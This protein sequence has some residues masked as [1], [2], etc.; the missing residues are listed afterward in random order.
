MFLRNSATKSLVGVTGENAYFG[1]YEAVNVGLYETPSQALPFLTAR[2]FTG[3]ISGAWHQE[4]AIGTL[5]LWPKRLS[6]KERQDLEDAEIHT[7][8]QQQLWPGVSV[9][10]DQ[11]GY[12]SL[13]TI[14]IMATSCHMKKVRSGKVP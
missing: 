2:C 12:Q 5:N 8:I 10:R 13:R 1:R 14:T 7:K 3:D 9:H 11:S 6:R 4:I